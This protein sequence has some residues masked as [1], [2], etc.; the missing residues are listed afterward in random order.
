V[1]LNENCS[2]YTQGK[3][4]S[5]NVEIRDETE[6]FNKTPRDRDVRER[7]YNPGKVLAK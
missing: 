7:D 2:E 6:T 5:E 1:D 4:D 3:V